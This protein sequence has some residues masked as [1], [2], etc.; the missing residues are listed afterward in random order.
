MINSHDSPS[1]KAKA[2]PV[3]A[4]VVG[5]CS[6]GLTI[7]F[8]LASACWIVLPYTGYVF[9]A[10]VFLMA[11]VLTGLRWSRGPVLLLAATSAIVWNFLFIP[12]QFT[13]HIEKPQDVIMFVLF[14]LIALSMGHL[15]TRLH[16]REQSL[17]RQQRETQILLEV[18]QSAALSPGI[19]DG[20]KAALDAIKKA[21]GADAALVL[22]GSKRPHAASRFTPTAPEWQAIAKCE[23][24][25]KPAGKH[26]HAF[27]ELE[28]SWLP[29]K[30]QSTT[31]GVIG[32]RWQPDA[33]FDLASL[34]MMEALSLQLALVLEKEQLLAAKRHADLLAESE[35]L[36][37]SLLDSV[38]HELKTP[39]AVIRTALDGLGNSNPFA[40]EIETATLR[41]QR[42][43]ENFLEMTRM[44]SEVLTAQKDWCDVGDLLDASIDPIGDA[45]LN[46][47]LRIEGADD[48]PLLK[49][50][51]RLLAQ[52]LSNVLHNAALYSPKGTAIELTAR[53][54]Q[55]QL[56]LIV[57][58]HGPGLPVESLAHVF[59]KFYRAPGTP[60]GG[61]GLGLA[62]AQGF[63]QAQGGK[64]SVRNHPEG[65]AE[66]TLSIPTETHSV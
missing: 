16:Q 14:F 63:I 46:H 47:P 62:I 11:I 22:D 7:L 43:V 21:I 28:T 35:R 40:R 64:I 34:P 52:A 10:L 5:Q 42:I 23:E 66:F 27:P 38:S 2:E 49:L 9:S 39:I 12:P 15:T 19:V 24:S 1:P 41:L 32:F 45:L 60:A 6:W 18:V 33:Q 53:L 4:A 36:H 65:G 3:T 17:E 48:L 59:D 13:L 50:D 54:N 61:T 56:E 57:R 37:R 26:M 31:L 8:V 58:D 44:E 30:T 29:L 25:G 20:F 51:S 55:H